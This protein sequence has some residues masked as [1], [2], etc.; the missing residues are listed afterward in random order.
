METV[1]LADRH[2]ALGSKLENWNGMGAAWTYD[3]LLAGSLLATGCRRARE[4]VVGV[5]KRTAFAPVCN[6]ADTQRA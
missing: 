6:R 3:A 5:G 1:G 2:R 4:D